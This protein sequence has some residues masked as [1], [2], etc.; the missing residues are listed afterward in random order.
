MSL[1]GN[2]MTLTIGPLFFSSSSK[3]T[4]NQHPMEV[5]E[6]STTIHSPLPRGGA[7]SRPKTID[8]RLMVLNFEQD[9]G[10]VLMEV[11]TSWWLNLSWLNL[12]WVASATPTIVSIVANIR[13]IGRTFKHSPLGPSK[14]MATGDCV[15]QKKLL[16]RWCT[17]FQLESKLPKQGVCL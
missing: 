17:L 14:A 15:A 11:E 12:L 3:L 4:N 1:G 9:S 6:V 7:V 13:L 8:Y 10:Y 2:M 5:V 16:S